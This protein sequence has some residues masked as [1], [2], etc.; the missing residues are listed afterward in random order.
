MTDTPE[1]PSPDGSVLLCFDGSKDAAASIARAG[2]LLR[3]G[4][5]VVVTVWEPVKVWA[6]Y[7][8]ATIIT[9][10]LTRLA[11]KELDLDEMARDVAQEK[12]ERGIHLAREAGFDPHGQLGRG[13]AWR[14][15]CD[16]AN[17]LDACLIVLGAR[18]LSRVQSALLGSV[19]AAVTVH[20][21]RPVLVVSQAVSPD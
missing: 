9:A 2:A 11:S 10:P 17:E 18:G 13:K 7:D 5:A 16:V 4:R 20:A 15:I 12:L 1:T 8:P 6:G 3:P 21:R 14:A 19:S